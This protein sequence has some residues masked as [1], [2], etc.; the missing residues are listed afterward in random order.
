M[1][2]KG[3]YKTDVFLP[4]L[5]SRLTGKKEYKFSDVDNLFYLGE[6]YWRAEVVEVDG[7]IIGFALINPSCPAEEI[8]TVEKAMKILLKT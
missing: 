1:I 7:R 3:S 8:E 4:L 5:S 6:G 2:S